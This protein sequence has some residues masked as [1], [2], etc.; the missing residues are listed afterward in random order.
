MSSPQRGEEKGGWGDS[1]PRGLW[2][3]ENNTSFDF[4][5]DHMK[6][7]A[8]KY[9]YVCIFLSL[10]LSLLFPG[11]NPPMCMAC[12]CVLPRRL[13]EA[14]RSSFRVD[15]HS[16][17]FGNGTRSYIALVVVGVCV[18]IYSSRREFTDES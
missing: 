7:R 15:T 6:K 18:C 11:Y 10:S 12:V 17:H 16:S 9:S 8:T 13:C 2:E 14:Y 1:V 3:E 4:D 5:F